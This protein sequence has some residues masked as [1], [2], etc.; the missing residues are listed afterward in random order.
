MQTTSDDKVMKMLEKLKNLSYMLVLDDLSTLQVEEIRNLFPV[1]KNT[2]III[3]TKGD[4][5][6]SHNH[7]GF[8]LFQRS[9]KKAHIN[10]KDDAEEHNC[11]KR[12]IEESKEARWPQVRTLARL[13]VTNYSTYKLLSEEEGSSLA[14]LIKWDWQYHMLPPRIRHCYLY[15]ALFPQAF[16]IPMRRLIRLWIAEG[17]VIK[18]DLPSTKTLEDVALN[19]LVQLEETSMIQVTKKNGR[20]KTCRISAEKYKFFSWKAQDLGVFI[21][22]NELGHSAA[23]SSSLPNT[24][25]RRLAEHVDIKNYPSGDSYIKQLC[26]YI[27]FT[28]KKDTPAL[29]V[30][31]FLDKHTENGFGLL[32][33]L[34]LEGVYKPLLKEETLGKLFLLTYLGLRWTFI[35]SLP[36]SVG[37]LQHLDTLDVKHTNIT[38]L[39]SSIWKAKNLRHLYMNQVHLDL[40][41]KKDFTVALTN[42]QTL[43]GLSIGSNNRVVKAL[44]YLNGLRKLGLTYHPSTAQEIADW[45]AKLTNLQSLRLRS[46]DVSGKPSDLKSLNM[47]KLDNLS[48]LYLVGELKGQNSLRFP[49]NLKSVTLTGSQ[50]EESGP[51]QIL[52]KLNQLKTLRLYGKSF[53]GDKIRFYREEFPKLI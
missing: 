20:S 49:C 22:H 45:V 40:S 25:A 46:I 27:N 13:Y 35:D 41:T 12:I 52:G 10:W 38:T 33:V 39:P 1:E 50:F 32:R 6:L 36:N 7:I 30:G 48:D 37:A 24:K 26:S 8:E 23:E 51:M 14:S 43:W 2:V 53:I 44:N 29:Q 9:L 42:L 47:S 31:D 17:L 21:V 16:E 11:L 19:Y 4:P 5:N 28:R 34:D 3:T 18:S 15:M